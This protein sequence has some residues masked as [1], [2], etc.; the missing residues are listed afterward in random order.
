MECSR[1]DLEGH[2]KQ[3]CKATVATVAANVVIE[4]DMTALCESFTEKAVITETSP[5]PIEDLELIRGVYENKKAQRG[6]VTLYSDSQAECTRNGRCGMEIGMSRE[7]DQGAVLKLFLG[8]K[9]NLEIDNTLP[10]DFIVGK[11]KISSKHSQGKV[12]LPV[13]AKWTSADTSVKEAIQAMIDADNSYYPT[14]L[15]TYLDTKDKKITVICIPS[16]HNKDVI[17]TLKQDAF[18]IPKGNSRG[19]EY[20]KK[21]MAK[22][23]EKIYFR[24]EILGVDLKGGLD[25]IERRISLL[26]GLGISP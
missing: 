3:I 9:I 10:E 18:T 22:L 19:V 14:L 21:A 17:K 26:R 15:I 25:P 4:P 7:K 23:F 24:I 6:L 16:E 13:K 8:D 12:G 20:S 11:E 5:L 2:T 1:G